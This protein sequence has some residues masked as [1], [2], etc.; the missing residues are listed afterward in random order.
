M[1]DIG[2]LGGTSAVPGILCDA[3]PRNFVVGASFIDGNI[4]ASTGIRTVAPFLWMDGKMADLGT[5]SGAI[6]ATTST[7]SWEKSSANQI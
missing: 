1:R 4:N 2:T 3:Q 7:N 5:L 6:G